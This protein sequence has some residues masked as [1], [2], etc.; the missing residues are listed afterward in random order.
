MNR[1]DRRADQSRQRKAD[2]ES[3]AHRSLVRA[4]ESM[5]KGREKSGDL[6]VASPCG[7]CGKSLDGASHADGLK[8]KP[9]DISL[10]IYCCNVNVF[11]EDLRL[12]KLTDEQADAHEC[13]SE[14]R[15][16]QTFLRSTM[17]KIAMGNKQG[18][19]EA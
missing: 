9:G 16:Q 1:R 8:A 7:H 3:E 5:G 4:V 18:T 12:Q 15:Q 14:I 2:Y 13:A 6:V 17:G 11:G 10:C 19:P